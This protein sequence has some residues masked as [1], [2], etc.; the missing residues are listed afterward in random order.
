MLL[1]TP[2]SLSFSLSVIFQVSLVFVLS[3]ITAELSKVNSAL[4]HFRGTSTDVQHHGKEHVLETSLVI[5]TKI[6]HHLQANFTQTLTTLRHLFHQ[7]SFQICSWKK[8]VKNIWKRNSWHYRF[9]IVRWIWIVHAQ[10]SYNDEKIHLLFTLP[11]VISVRKGK[12]S[13][14]RLLCA[15]VDEK[16]LEN[17]TSML[18][19]DLRRSRHTDYSQQHARLANSDQGRTKYAI[20]S[21][22]KTNSL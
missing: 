21:R 14:S 16:I 13:R 9:N 22:M 4:F 11:V 5:S 2:L 7:Y 20:Y 17:S 6:S 12:S 1:S 10:R 8:Q 18:E 15:F 19:L 3:A